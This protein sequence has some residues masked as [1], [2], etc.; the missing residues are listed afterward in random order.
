MNFAVLTRK[1]NVRPKEQFILINK[2][3][4]KQL[5]F[6][7]AILVIRIPLVFFFVFLLLLFFGIPPFWALALEM[8]LLSFKF[9]Y[10]KIF[11]Q[12]RRM[13]FFAR[14]YFLLFVF[15]KKHCTVSVFS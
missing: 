9:A 12:R 7:L 15:L 8:V 14:F 10:L 1:C 4:P 13:S 6:S 3:L 11:W 5:T 2:K